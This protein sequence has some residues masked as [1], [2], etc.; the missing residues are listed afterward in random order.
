MPILS[1]KKLRKGGRFSKR[2]VGRVDDRDLDRGL[3][4]AAQ[5]DEL[6]E[7]DGG[8]EDGGVQE[9]DAAD[10]EDGGVGRGRGVRQQVRGGRERHAADLEDVVERDDDDEDENTSVARRRRLTFQGICFLGDLSRV[11]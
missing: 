2:A 4:L 6:L 3:E 10:F 11:F 8:R 9:R 7:D 1:R 5:L